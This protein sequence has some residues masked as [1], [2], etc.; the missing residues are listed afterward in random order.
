MGDSMI[1][2][3]GLSVAASLSVSAS[4]VAAQTPA[5][6]SS[7]SGDTAWVTVAAIMV[8]FAA[9][10]GLLCAYGGAVR[11]KNA[12]AT[13]LQGAAVA[14]L[15][16]L[17]WIAIGYTVSFGPV[18]NGW[19]GGGGSWMLNN[20]GNFRVGLNIPESTFVLFEMGLAVFASVLM[21]GA[22]AE[23]A[24]PLWVMLFCALWSVLIYAPIAHW[25][26][27]GGWLGVK[28][29]TLDYAGGIT[30]HITAGVSALVVALLIG[31]R[32]GFPFRDFTPHAPLL[33]LG[34][35][36]LLWVGWLGLSGGAA[37]TATDDTSAAIIN[38]H[39]AAC[40]GLF[41]FLI[42]EWVTA[43][44]ITV[45]GSGKGILAGLVA[46]TPAAGFVSPGAAVL[47]GAGGAILSFGAAR[48]IRNALQI[49][50]PMDVFATHA[51]SGMFG[52]LALGVFLAPQLGGTGYASGMNMARQMI[53]QTAGAGTAIAVAVVGS[54]IL[55]LGISL[56]IPMRISEAQENDG[57]DAVFSEPEKEPVEEV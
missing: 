25:V 37:L 30:V 34:G 31:K 32:S 43:R 14:A 40:L 36:F 2:K 20:L 18:T 15:V 45:F 8:L 22:W 35:G 33:A 42:L 41:T 19:V 38:T 49:D 23:R 12:L 29:G 9:L 47:I 27:G 7:D 50:D 28:F 6:A 54:A 24:R 51:V 17:L 16:S 10:P 46:I 11:S 44:K 55:A 56:F 52:T 3:L 21:I 53:A 39:V 57:L 5:S 1:R 48:F 13:S 4:A 26:W